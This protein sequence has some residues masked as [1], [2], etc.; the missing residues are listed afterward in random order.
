VDQAIV[1]TIIGAVAGL[2]SGTL[3]SL[4]APWANWGIEKRRNL[5]ESR[6]TLLNETREL[7]AASGFGGF[8]FSQKPIYRRLK[9]YLRAAIVESVENFEEFDENADDP[10]E[11]RRYFRQ[12]LLDEIARLERDWGLL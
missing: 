9:P 12:E 10:A 11:H 8:T 3:G 5:R 4:I 7:V 1:T 6:R 2:I